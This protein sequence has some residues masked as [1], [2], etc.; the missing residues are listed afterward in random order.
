MDTLLLIIKKKFVLLS[1]I[2]F[3][4]TIILFALPSHF[5]VQQIY[6]PYLYPQIRQLLNH[7]FGSLPF[8]SVLIILAFIL[9]LGIYIVAKQILLKNKTLSIAYL[10]S[11]I[12]YLLV[13]FFW[14]WGFYYNDQILIPQPHIEQYPLRQNTVLKTFHKAENYRTQLYTDSIYPEWNEKMLTLIEDSG[15]IWL[16]QTI[17]QLGK[18]PNQSSK[19][20]RKWPKGFLL[21]WG[22]VGMYFP[23]SGES[24]IDGGLHAIRYPSTVLHELAH[25]MGFTNE[26][27]CNLIAYLAAQKTSNSFIRYSAELERLREEMYFA[28]MQNSN[29]F[30]TLKKDLPQQIEKDLNQIR[31]YHAKYR[32]KLTDVGNWINDQYLKALSGE[33]GIDEYWLWVIKLQILEDKSKK[34]KSNTI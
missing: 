2:L 8:S 32:G 15:R 10:L 9:I 25:S 6:S 33:N 13:L 14:I 7:S 27:D 19:Q 16:T 29:L 5:F 34:Q 17:E 28:A 24:T 26:G 3:T 11:Y 22:I 1:L 30:D 20:I 4:I 31:A 23:F 12:L 18:V 21:R